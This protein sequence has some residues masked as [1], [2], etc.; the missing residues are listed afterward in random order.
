MF[1]NFK[2]KTITIDELKKA[3]NIYEHKELVKFIDDLINQDKLQPIKSS[4]K[5]PNYP[6]I[7]KKYKIIQKNNENSELIKELN[8][9]YFSLSPSFYKKNLN[10]Y[11]KHRD[12][13]KILNSYLI[14]NSSYLNNK[15]SVNERS[16]E[17]FRD[18][19]FLMSDLGKE[20]C[21]HLNLDIYKSLNVYPTPE[22][23]CYYS[24]SSKTPQKILIIENKDTFI[25][26]MKLFVLGQTSILGEDISTIIYGEGYKIKS[27]FDYIYEDLTINY[28]SNVNNEIL[29]WG[30]IDREGFVIYEVFKNKYA[31]LNIK[32]FDKAYEL[33]IN[34]SKSINLS[35]IKNKQKSNYKNSLEELHNDLKEEIVNIIDN[36]NYI[37]Q[38]ILNI[39]DLGGSYGA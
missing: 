21:S 3:F 15:I 22:P 39:F 4:E 11:E 13:I 19:K 2:K 36:K 16:Y 32:L 35:K 23:F 26:V 1:S 20:I 6:Q 31:N 5:T 38:E 9:L 37:P 30:D 8:T 29:Y 7:H 33:M 10:L 34:K 18:E 28:L 14:N 12:Y 17:I 27:S 24:I 25:S